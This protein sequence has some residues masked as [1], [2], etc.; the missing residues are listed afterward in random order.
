MRGRGT[1]VLLVLFAVVAGYATL[2]ERK[3][4]P[5]EEREAKA[6]VILDLDPARISAVAFDY[7]DSGVALERRGAGWELARLRPGAEAVRYAADESAVREVT[8]FFDELRAERVMVEADVDTAA[9]GL[10]DPWVRVRVAMGDTEHTLAVG[11]QNPTRSA[12]YARLDGGRAIALLATWTVDSNLK[13]TVASLRDRRLARF[14]PEAARRVEL[15]HPGGALVLEASDGGW[16]IAGPAPRLAA[17][18]SAV[19][20]LLGRLSQLEAADFVEDEAAAAAARRDLAEPAITV[21]VRG[22]RDSL[23]ARLEVGSATGASGRHARSNAQPTIAVVAPGVAEE[24]AV[25]VAELRDRRLVDLGAS[26]IDSLRVVAG[27]RVVA[28]AASDP[29][30]ERV[31]SNLPHLRVTRFADEMAEAPADLHRYG[32]DAPALR[33]VL[34]LRNGEPR[35]VLF[36]AAG[37]DGVYAHRVGRPGVVVVSPS[38]VEDLERLVA[39]PTAPDR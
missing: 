1:L 16:W 36:G 27:D 39:G 34:R 23:L 20:S 19:Q 33:L 14:D 5:A 7:A 29:E 25:G 38:T 4:P 24:L 32:L 10:A 13:R 21:E 35:E 28:G 2:V 17:D 26:E 30:I 3:R 15:G 8:A 31:A 12:Y 6:K 37:A 11:A 9:T 22:E 18:P